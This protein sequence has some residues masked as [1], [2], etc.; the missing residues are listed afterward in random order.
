MYD[1]T[2]F[3]QG[4]Q[5]YFIAV[6]SAKIIAALVTIARKCI[7]SKSLLTGKWVM[8]CDVWYRIL[9]IGKEKKQDHD[10]KKT[11]I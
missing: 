5:R 10:S 6:H 7:E 1:S 2:C 4:L 8:K 11:N 3:H 9:F